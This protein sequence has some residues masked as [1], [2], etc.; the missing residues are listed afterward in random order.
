MNTFASF[1]KYTQSGTRWIMHKLV[2]ESG[3]DQW[4]FEQYQF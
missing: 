3:Q 1:I 4:K 2:L